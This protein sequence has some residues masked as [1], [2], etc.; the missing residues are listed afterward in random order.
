MKGIAFSDMRGFATGNVQCSEKSREMSGGE[1]FLQ[2]FDKTQGQTREADTQE[3][4]VVS[5]DADSIQKHAD[6]QKKTTETVKKVE[7]EN[8][9]TEVMEEAANEVKE[10]IAEIFDVS[11]DEVESVLESLGLCTLDLLNTN[12]LNQVVME[13]NPGLDALQLMTNEELYA[14]F[15]ELLN[16]AQ[17]MKAQLCEQFQMTEEELKA[18]MESAKELYQVQSEQSELMGETVDAEVLETVEVVE[19]ANVTKNGTEFIEQTAIEKAVAE[20]QTSMEP[21]P[22][23]KVSSK[24]EDSSDTGFGN[25]SGQDMAKNFFN[26]LSEAVENVSTSE[27][28][29]YGTSGQDIIRQ[30]TDYIKVNV[31]ADTT[32]ME[33]QLH[34]ASLGNV[35]V[36]LASTGG[37]LTAI[38]TTENES[39]KAALEAQLIQLKDNFTQQGLK[40]ESIEVNVSAQGFERNLEQQNREQNSFN[41]EKSKKGN[42]RIRLSDVDSMDE[43]ALEEL[44]EEDKVV[45]D[46]M[47]RNGNTVDYTV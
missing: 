14:D 44:A 15:K 24:R 28:T 21:I 41:E 38:F 37:V 3:V 47:I 2:V 42:R 22:M 29:T 45:A 9:S 6:L 11:V 27:T 8:V 43:I 13:L 7:E 23:E 46:M 30:I 19:T 40:V 18:V 36:Q 33:L 1:S 26:K 16:F 25:E 4:K 10:K 20:K 12:V 17:G 35:K 31:K 39:V 32:E 5:K 34:P